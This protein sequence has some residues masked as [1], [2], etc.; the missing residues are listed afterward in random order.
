MYNKRFIQF[1]LLTQKSFLIEFIQSFCIFS[2][3]DNVR[4]FTVHYKTW[5]YLYNKYRY[6]VSVVC[7]FLQPCLNSVIKLRPQCLHLGER[8]VLLLCRFMSTAKGFKMLSDANFILNEVQKWEKVH[9]HLCH[10]INALQ[11]INSPSFYSMRSFSLVS[12]SCTIYVK[13]K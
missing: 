13:F 7:D 5:E 6:I 9:Q 11:F 12:M 10:T 3:N 1:I 2:I 8:G 4:L